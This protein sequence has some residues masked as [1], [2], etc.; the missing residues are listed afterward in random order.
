MPKLSPAHRRFLS[1]IFDPSR[2]SRRFI[3]RLEHDGHWQMFRVLR[4]MGMLIRHP[5]GTPGM[6]IPTRKAVT[7]MGFEVPDTLVLLWA[8]PLVK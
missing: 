7:E 4:D 6:Y 8:E 5:N 2:R 3:A 1:K